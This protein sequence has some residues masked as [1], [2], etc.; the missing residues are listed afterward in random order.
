LG[1]VRGHLG[2]I[3]L[4]S[5]PG[6]GTTFTILL[7]CFT[8]TA[9]EAS[10]LPVA[11]QPWRGE[12][13]VLVADDEEVVRTIARRILEEAGFEVIEAQD[14]R[15]AVRIFEE[16]ADGIVAVLLDMTMPHLSGDEAFRQMRLISPGIRIILS[17]GFS[18]QDA[19]SRFAGK[20]LTGFLQKPYRAIELL[21]KLRIVLGEDI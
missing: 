6:K 2:A 18:E 3:R 11:L 13:T 1:I 14:G 19:T 12:G 21:Q 17:S 9:K 8:G 20:G 5:E 10:K 4:Q 15:E 16:R 7:P